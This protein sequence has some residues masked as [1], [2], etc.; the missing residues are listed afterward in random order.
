MRKGAR[1]LALLV[2]GLGLL[3]WAGQSIF[4]S[5][6][7]AWFDRDVELRDRL[8]VSTTQT[9]IVERLRTGD[10][11]A[12]RD[13]L[14]AII[15]DERIMAVAMCSDT[16]RTVAVSG[17]YPAAFGCSVLPS[18]KKMAGEIRDNG[19]YGLSTDL[20][21]GPVH[22][23]VY[24]IFEDDIHRGSV[25]LLHDMSFVARRDRVMRN[26]LLVAFAILAVS[27]ALVTLVAAQLSWRGFLRELRRVLR[28]GKAGPEF[29]PLLRDIR[30]LAKTLAQETERDQGDLRWTPERLKRALKQHLEGE[31]VIVVANRAPYIH[32]KRGAKIEVVHPA[33][34]LVTALE[35]VLRACSGVW[36]AHGSGSADRE[37]ADES[38]RIRVP[39]GDESYSLRRVW[40]SK[41]E[42][43][44]YYYGFANEGLWPLCHV[45]HTRPTFRAEDFAYYKQV[46]EKFAEAV[47]SEVDRDDPI[48]LVQD[49]H[50]A[51]AP[52]M[53]RAR[54][55]KATILTFW[56]IPWPNA[57]RFGICPWRQELVEGLLGS[58]IMGFHTQQHCNNFLE[59]V[60]S[61]VESRID[62]ER[63]AVV[64]GARQSLVRPYPISIEWPVHWLDGMP[65]VADCKKEVFAQLGLKDDA[66]LGVGVD[67]LDYTKG[68]EERLLAVER[69]LERFPK[70]I[71][72][73][74]FV[75]IAAPSRTEIERYQALT[76]TVERTVKRINERF[77]S[78]DYRPV[79]LLREHHEPRSVYKF[80]RAA[81]LCYV[82]SLHD[83]MN[84]VSK[85]F[86]AARDDLRGVLVL[87]RFTGAARELTEAVIV[88][89][90]DMDESSSAL[91]FALDMPIEEQVERM[92]SM[93]ALVSE[94]NIF[95]WAGRM[96]VDAAQLRRKDRIGGRLARAWP[97]GGTV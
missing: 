68:I 74:T 16:G 22:L 14:E 91:S 55:P 35:P 23:G 82:S 56:H 69:M 94:F 7:R 47:V 70:Y 72:R 67:R 6:T 8:I 44:G 52:A 18:L 4:T 97:V 29:K 9:Q 77:G 19:S 17:P 11:R 93:R 31:R 40:L 80:Y 87:S 86:I 26:M 3:T 53:I 21:G 88:N 62:R 10:D 48:V 30:E 64:Q 20:T 32:E 92:R 84:L 2:V 61:F 83:G 12:I 46:N 49:Y 42:E 73:F 81:R 41:E 45:A 1:F 95:R 63:N 76:E 33:S 36:V 50:F 71:G 96:L 78:G 38:G 34:G 75:Q 13:L 51:L 39:P 15:V 25:A 79:I 60:D 28:G 37:T 24:E 59:S 85:E 5:K 54:L 89:P 43:K 58:S 57:E 27:A 90:Y 65:S 66:L